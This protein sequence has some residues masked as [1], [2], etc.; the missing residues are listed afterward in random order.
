MRQTRTLCRAVVLWA[1]VLLTPC[2]AS[3]SGLSA[4]SQDDPQ[5]QKAIDAVETGFEAAAKCES[6]RGATGAMARG[7][8][9]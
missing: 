8:S 4:A 2:L 5:S 7:F 6:C 1:I 3:A 9:G